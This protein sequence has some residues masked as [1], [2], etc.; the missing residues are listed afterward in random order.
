M[1]LE[2]QPPV[3]WDKGKIVLWLLARQTFLRDEHSILPIYVG[4]NLA[5]EDAFRVLQNKGL[6]I[7]I[8][9]SK[10]SLAEYYLNNSQEVSELLRRILKS[11]PKIF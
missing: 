8:G 5:D 1:I 3:V 2:I 10:G 9:E 7:C 4:N 6:T 11:I